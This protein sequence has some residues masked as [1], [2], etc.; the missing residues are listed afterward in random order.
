LK[1]ERL[2]RINVHNNPVNLIDPF[3]LQDLNPMTGTVIADQNGVKI[4]HYGTADH[5]PAHAHV[6]GG[7]PE[8]K[9]GPKG[10]PLKNQPSLTPKQSKVVRNN[11]QAIRRELNKLGRANMRLGNA[12]KALGSLG[13]I[14]ILLDFIN[15]QKRADERGVSVWRILNE[16]MGYSPYRYICPT[17][18]LE[19]GGAL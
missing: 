5:G 4:E 2:D 14:L 7:G 16:D 12:G 11:Q 8:T 15:A 18:A 10:Y 17:G 1:A 9:I 3:G 19:N 6:K 13:Q